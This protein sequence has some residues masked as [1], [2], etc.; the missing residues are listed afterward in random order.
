MHGIPERRYLLNTYVEERTCMQSKENNSLSKVAP[1]I[2]GICNTQN[3]HGGRRLLEVV[4]E[5]SHEYHRMYLPH[6]FTDTNIC[7]QNKEKE[8]ISKKKCVWW[9]KPV[10]SEKTQ[11][12]RQRQDG[13]KFKGNLAY[14]KETLSQRQTKTKAQQEQKH[15]YGH[16]FK[17]PALR[18][19]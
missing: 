2:K 1:W 17:Y 18:Y 6:T 16:R 13:S 10:K 19:I 5:S 4:Y 12:K 15:L 9:Q 14:I 3:L 8:I 7:I 11:F